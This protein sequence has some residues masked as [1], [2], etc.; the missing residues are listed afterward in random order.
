MSDMTEEIENEKTRYSD[1]HLSLVVL[2]GV[3]LLIQLPNFVIRVVYIKNYQS[4]DDW[5]VF[6]VLPLLFLALTV[7]LPILVV[8]ITPNLGRFDFKWFSWTRG[9]FVRFWLLPLGVVASVVIVRFLV[10]QLRLPTT[11]RSIRFETG[12]YLCYYMPLYV[13]LIIRICVLT[14]IIEEFF[15]RGYV[16][17]I[18]LKICHPVFAILGQAILFGLLHFPPVLGFLEVSLLG[19]VF[20]IWC[21]R[22]KTLLPVIVMHIAINSFLFTCEWRDRHEVS[23]VKVTHNYVSKFI[24]LSKPDAYDFR[25]DARVQ[26][27][28]ANLFLKEIPKELEELRKCY[29]T[30][31]S[32]EELTMAEAWILSNTQTLNLIEKGTQKPYYW[33][34]YLRRSNRFSSRMP[35]LTPNLYK[36]KHIIF[37]LCMRAMLKTSQGQFDQGFSD[38]ETCSQLGSHLVANKDSLTKLYGWACYSFTVKAMRMILSHENIDSKF[39]K[40]L[41][42]QFEIL[43]EQ[44]N[45]EFDL[46]GERFLLLDAIQCLFTDDGQGGGRIPRCFFRK[47]YLQGGKFEY[48]QPIFSLIEKSNIKECKRLERRE[49]TAQVEIYCDI[50][51][52]VFSLSPWQYERDYDGLKTS[53]EQIKKENP[54]IKTF[55]V[56]PQ[57]LFISWRARIDLDALITILAILRYKEDTQQYPDSLLELVVKGYIEAVPDDPYGDGQIIYKQ[58]DNGFLLYSLGV[59]F[60]DDGGKPYKST[61]GKMDGDDIFWPVE[62]TNEYIALLPKVKE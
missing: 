21:Y 22:R 27:S 5:M 19:L 24:E 4:T 28:K 1:R 44:E 41:Q 31:W 6:F 9:E 25:E 32:R 17:S 16:Q 29:P 23:Q 14:P 45:F 46:T 33:V 2:A 30:Q 37:A 47:R 7:I 49:T 52:K 35:V 13:W 56:N 54:I 36:M 43:T 58:T 18:L 26:Y 10:Y 57:L 59:D 53:I 48:I 15:W 8:K 61:E 20:G 12:S 3:I 39:L 51:E 11:G 34:G 50:L 55:S 62:G 40:N 42:N 38:I 60:D